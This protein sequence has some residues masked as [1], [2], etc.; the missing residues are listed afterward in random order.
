MR[1]SQGD[2]L[3]EWLHNFPSQDPTFFARQRVNLHQE[4]GLPPAEPD[5]FQGLSFDLEG[6]AAYLDTL[7]LH[8]VLKLPPPSDDNDSDTDG[9]GG[10][11]DDD[12]VLCRVVETVEKLNLEEEGKEENAHHARE[13]PPVE[14]AALHNESLDDVVQPPLPSL[15]SPLPP[16]R[17]HTKPQVMGVD[18]DEDDDELD[19]LLGLGIAGPSLTTDTKVP[20][21]TKNTASTGEGGMHVAKE[22]QSLEDW[23]DTL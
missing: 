17:I 6:L 9:G 18:D 5:T 1:R 15:S 16:P 12:A 14:D 13:A 3:A 21:T 8:Q 11:D 2:D 7:P 23:L 22:T 19:A 4:V 20:P 10:D